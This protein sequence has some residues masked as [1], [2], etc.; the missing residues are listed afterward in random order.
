MAEIKDSGTRR[1]FETGATRDMQEGKGRCD[2][3][4]L[5]LV[6]KLFGYSVLVDLGEFMWNGKK[7]ILIKVIRDFAE[8]VFG[9][10]STALLEYAKHLE[11]GCKKYGPRNW[12]QGIPASSFLDSAVRHYLKFRR[13]DSDERHDRAFLWNTIGLLYTIEIMPYMNDLPY[14]GLLE[15]NKRLFVDDEL[16]EVLSLIQQNKK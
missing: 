7:E 1:T 16:D 3:M 15:A 14:M 4:P 5:E 2:L 11:D 12:E 10:P 9:E 6:G 13:G 8:K